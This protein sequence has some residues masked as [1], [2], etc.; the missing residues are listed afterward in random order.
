MAKGGLIRDGLMR[1]CTL[2]FN[3]SK[4]PSCTNPLLI[5]LFIPNQ[6]IARSSHHFNAILSLDLMAQRVE[7]GLTEDC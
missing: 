7:S 4:H 2:N 6:G 5:P 3:D 1:E